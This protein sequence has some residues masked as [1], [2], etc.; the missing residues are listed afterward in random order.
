MTYIFKNTERNNKRSSDFETKSMLYL[1]GQNKDKEEIEYVIFDCFNDV[2]GINEDTDSIWDIQSKNEQSMNP[3]KIG[4]YF[5]TLFDNYISSFNFKEFIF[6]APRLK[7]DYK[8]DVQL[9]VYN[10]DNFQDKTLDR[11]KIGLN[12][13]IIRVKGNQV[14]YDLEQENFLKQIVIVEDNKNESEYIKTVTNFKNLDIKDENF[15]KSIF[16]ELRDIQTAKKNSYIENSTISQ[17]IEVL[18]F[19]RH[20][21]VKDI[22]TLIISRIIGCELFTYKSIPLYFSPLLDG[23]DIEDKKDI[24]QRCN[25]NLSKAFF[26]KN[27][28]QIFWRVCEDIIAFLENNAVAD[29]TSAFETIFPQYK[30]KISYL[31]AITIKYL[32]SII[33]EGVENDNSK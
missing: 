19:Q 7:S 17:I 5:Y 26:D 23:K 3:K 25:S 13:E 4:K 24:L 6:F 12:E 11:I 31:S 2:S 27:S 15:Y 29:I 21:S 20:L 28:N 14:N 10:T 33:I 1:I 16:E 30:P 8:K 18:D 9:S 22:E 32:I